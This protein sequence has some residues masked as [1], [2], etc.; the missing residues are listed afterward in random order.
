V[1]TEE[2]VDRKQKI[3]NLEMPSVDA[4]GGDSLAKKKGE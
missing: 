4:G 3:Q 2:V 1:R